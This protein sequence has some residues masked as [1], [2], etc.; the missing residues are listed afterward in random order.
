VWSRAR[1]DRDRQASL[2]A[3]IREREAEGTEAYRVEFRSLEATVR[4]LFT[5]SE[6]LRHLT[7]DTL[8]THHDL[9]GAA[10]YLAVPPISEDDFRTLSG[11]ERASER[12][13]RERAARLVALLRATMDP[14]RLPWLQE[15]R[16]TDESEREHAIRWTTGVWAVERIRTS[17]RIRSSHRQEEAVAALIA[18][19]D[20]QEETR[21][22]RIVGLDDLPRRSFCR[23]VLLAGAKCDIAV[24]LSDGRLL[25]LECK[26]SNSPINSVKRLIRE[27]GGKARV[28]EKE[29]GRWVIPGVVISGV[30]K[31]THLVQAQRDHHITV[32]WE[33]NLRELRR[34]L[35]REG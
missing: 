25:A 21:R 4:R 22:R 24:R 35:T 1:L 5:V 11:M 7:E 13:D 27:T 17:R 19:A 30:Y 29:F 26:V 9:L 8:I 32:F 23:E 10:R 18:R 20:Y 31:L 3:F 16:P 34:F 15:R 14:I 28:W 6:D 12:L 33:H 2:E